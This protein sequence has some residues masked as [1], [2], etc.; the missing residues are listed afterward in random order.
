MS[1][2]HQWKNGQSIGLP[3]GKVVCVGRNYADHAAELNNPIPSEPILF[4][5]PGTSIVSLH[6]PIAIPLSKGAV[7][8]EAEISVLIG[9]IL[10]N[11]GRTQVV[12]GMIG[13]GAALDLTLRDLQAG[14]KE[15]GHPWE[16]AKAF[17]GSCPLS[18]FEPIQSFS[19]L[20][21][22]DIELAISGVIKQKG[23]SDQ[24]LFDIPSLIEY[25]STC[26][27]LMP[28]DVVL[29]GTP[30]GVG[31][32]TPGDPVQIRLCSH[33]AINTLVVAESA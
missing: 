9:K 31:P 1:Y 18:C 25:I 2:R 15:Q 12:E 16:K 27:T 28:G 23:S 7:H 33:F 30:K 6:E 8:Y 21:H 26:F 20:N 5:K 4:I 19:T 32:L 14:L 3:A 17:D 24:M 11:A 22:I 29:T 13:I 10:K